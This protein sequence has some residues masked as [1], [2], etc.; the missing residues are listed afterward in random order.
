MFFTSL[1]RKYRSP[2]IV[3]AAY[4]SAMVIKDTNDREKQQSKTLETI[5][6]ILPYIIIAIF[7]FLIIVK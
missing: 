1:Y 5:K 7:W 4:R 2:A 6:A 3:D